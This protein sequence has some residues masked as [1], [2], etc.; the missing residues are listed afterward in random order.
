MIKSVEEIERDIDNL[1]CL[2]HFSEAKYKYELSLNTQL[3]MARRIEELEEANKWQPIETA[4]KD[5]TEILIANKLDWEEDQED[6]RIGSGFTMSESWWCKNRNCWLDRCDFY[7][8]KPK[9]WKHI[10]KPEEK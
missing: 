8:T 1:D 9:Y 2:M 7:T 10:N 4:P 5:G 6:E 3:K